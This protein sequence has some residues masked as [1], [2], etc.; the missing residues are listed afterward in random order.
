[1]RVVIQCQGP[2]AAAR[3]T[4]APWNPTDIT[5]GLEAAQPAIQTGSIQRQLVLTFT[6]LPASDGVVGVDL[7]G[8]DNLEGREAPRRAGGAPPA[9]SNRLAGQG[10]RAVDGGTALCWSGRTRDGL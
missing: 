2:Q 5:R 1:M 7:G 8:Q 10:L 3:A 9:M 6:R 4:I